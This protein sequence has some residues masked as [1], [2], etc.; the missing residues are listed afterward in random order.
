MWLRSHFWDLVHLWYTSDRGV[1]Q[2][3]QVPEMA[4]QPQKLKKSKNE[5]MEIGGKD[6]ATGKQGGK[7]PYII[8]LP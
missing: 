5:K 2:M 6:T 1:P 7:A 4:S 3:S 8:Y